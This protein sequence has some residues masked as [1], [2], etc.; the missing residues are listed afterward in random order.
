MSLWERGVMVLLMAMVQKT[1]LVTLQ[2]I[3]LAK[4]MRSAVA[5]WKA[6]EERFCFEKIGSCSRTSCSQRSWQSLLIWD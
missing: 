5:C 4:A 2:K 3:K 6:R 1:T